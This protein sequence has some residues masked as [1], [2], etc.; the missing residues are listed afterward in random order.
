MQVTSRLR[1]QLP[2]GEAVEDIQELNC[3]LRKSDDTWRFEA[4]EVVEV[5]EQ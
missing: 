5:L 2:S 1:G 3:N 4:I